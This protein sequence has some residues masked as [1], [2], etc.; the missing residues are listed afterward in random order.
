MNREQD[1]NIRKKFML[2]FNEIVKKD[3]RTLCK[4]ERLFGINA[5]AMG[6]YRDGASVPNAISIYRICQIYGVSADWLLGL[7]DKG[8]PEE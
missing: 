7:S 8:G 3:G 1:Y 6:R 4:I 2:R 5:S